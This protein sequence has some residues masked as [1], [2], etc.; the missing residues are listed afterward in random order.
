MRNNERSL[1]R[2][3][4]QHA[5]Y[6]HSWLLKHSFNY[7]LD[8]LQRTGKGGGCKKPLRKREML[9]IVLKNSVDYVAY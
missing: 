3:E 8:P 7:R 1:F 2:I 4:V 5:S 9:Q 6:L